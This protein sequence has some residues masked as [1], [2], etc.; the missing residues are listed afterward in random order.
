MTGVLGGADAR[1]Q[2]AAGIAATSLA[3]S[4]DADALEALG[5][6]LTQSAPL[7]DVARAALLAHPPRDLEALLR[8]APPS[9]ARIEL[10]AELGDQRAFLPLREIVR[11]GPE[12][13]R[14]P[15]ALALFRLGALETQAYARY[16]F[17]KSHIPSERLAALQILVESKD[18]LAGPALAAVLS[19]KDDLLARDP[20]AERTVV[21]LAALAPRPEWQSALVGKAHSDDPT[22]REQALLALARLGGPAE[23]FGRALS[24]KDAAWA[25]R[26]LASS[27][28]PSLDAVLTRALADRAAR[29]WGTA[30]SF[31]AIAAR[32]I[33]A[34]TQRLRARR[35]TSAR[36]R[37][38]RSKSC[39]SLG[40]RRREPRTRSPPFDAQG[41]GRAKSRPASGIPRAARARGRARAPEG[42]T[43]GGGSVRTARAVSARR[44]SARRPFDPV[45]RGVARRWR[46]HVPG[47]GGRHRGATRRGS[48]ARRCA[49]HAHRGRAALARVGGARA[50]RRHCARSRRLERFGQRRLASRALSLRVGPACQAGGRARSGKTPEHAR[51]RTLRQAVTLDP[52]AAVRALAALAPSSADASA[53]APTLVWLA[54]S[55]GPVRLSSAWGGTMVV[56]PDPDG[57]V[58]VLDFGPGPITTM[59]APLS[60][61]P[62]AKL[63]SAR[64]PSPEKR[65]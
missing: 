22:V 43:G 48:S 41:R 51:L 20:S 59:P 61:A 4:G 21:E 29:P 54:P 60:E 27:S 14:G 64:D 1:D 18:E 50:A 16:A 37:N 58:G 30:R 53:N 17:Q 19:D 10:L 56:F 45:A 31:G 39:R 57:F 25:A 9:R 3:R 28:A 32:G 26:A 12:A 55:E 42:Q 36:Q 47:G 2:L 49:P 46:G 63:R 13:L 15:A 11:S 34:R 38:P 33:G 24:G 8:G 5:R 65:S 62:V 6:A 44:P 35:S 23:F 52:D 40:A 7:A